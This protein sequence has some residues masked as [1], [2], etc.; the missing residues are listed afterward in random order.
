MHDLARVTS[1]SRRDGL[2]R[3]PA[4]VIAASLASPRGRHRRR[5][6]AASR[7]TL[8]RAEWQAAAPDEA[9]RVGARRVPS[10]E[11]A[12]AHIAPLQQAHAPAA[13]TAG[14]STGHVFADVWQDLRYAIARVEEAT[15][16][17]LTA[18]LTLALGI[19]ATTAM[20]SVVNA[21]VIKPLPYPESENVVTVATRQYLEASDARLPAGAT[22][23]RVV[24]GERPIVRGIGNVRSEATVTGLGESGTREHAAGD[25]GVL[26]ALNVQ[27][28]LGRWFS[29]DDDR[30]GARGDGDLERRLLA[31]PLWRR[32]ESDRAH[33]HSRRQTPRGDWRDARSLHPPRDS[34]G[35]DSS[36]ALRSCTSIRASAGGFLLQGDRTAQAGS[37]GGR[38]QCR[39]RPHAADDL[40]ATCANRAQRTTSSSG[41][42]CAPSKKTSWATW[43][44]SCGSCWEVS[45][46][47]C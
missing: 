2:T 4:L 18:V 17:R 43:A 29:P 44:A 33:D 34:R 42:P 38:R 7:G 37:D 1:A 35:S 10:R 11:R 6:L 13:V 27:P 15:R 3:P 20:F 40:E 16:L 12:R 23:V 46:F 32:S 21:V 36:P 31:A 28:A 14:A 5:D 9:L 45:A 8:P 41:R 39:C 19:G 26:P 22:D 30:P 25:G 47:C 24:R